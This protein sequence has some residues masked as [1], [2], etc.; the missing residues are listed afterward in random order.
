MASIVLDDCI[1]DG[2]ELL[3][4]DHHLC[5]DV[6]N[7]DDVALTILPFP[8]FLL[9]IPLSILDK[10]KDFFQDLS[11]VS[12]RT[13]QGRNLFPIKFIDSFFPQVL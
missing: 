6:S 10:R 1:S 4:P 7:D 2:F 12:P 11:P 5:K 13:F 9:S 3:N 8:P